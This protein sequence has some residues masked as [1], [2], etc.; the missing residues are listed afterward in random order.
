M[1]TAVALRDPR[2]FV[3]PQVWEREIT[4][5]VRDNPFDEVMAER[6]FGQAVAYLI[7]AIEKWGQGLE[8]CCGRLVDMAVHAFIL[9]TRH[10]REFCEKHFGRFLEHIPEIE[11][12]YDGSVERTAHIIEDNGF[13]VD[14]PLWK[15]DFGK[16]GPCRPG[17]NCH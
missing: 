14:W 1:A 11:F 16:C 7:T 12:K 10:Y 2:A 15:R 3:D 5:M 13:A 17:E 6:L 9:D 4:L 8:M